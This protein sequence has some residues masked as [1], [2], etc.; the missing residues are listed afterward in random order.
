MAHPLEINYSGSPKQAETCSSRPLLSS[1]TNRN[2][3]DQASLAFVL[4]RR[5]WTWAT[6]CFD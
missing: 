5:W 6:V 3:K 2:K 1:F 4:R